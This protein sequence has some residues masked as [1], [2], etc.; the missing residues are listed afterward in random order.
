VKRNCV[1]AYTRRVRMQEEEFSR[2][3]ALL[4]TQIS[5]WFWWIRY[6]VSPRAH[7]RGSRR[8]YFRESFRPVKRHALDSRGYDW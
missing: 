1:M 3:C 7:S 2:C 5:N 6:V 4:V 8:G